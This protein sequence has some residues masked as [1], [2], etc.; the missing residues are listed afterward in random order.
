MSAP[1]SS[2]NSKWIALE[3]IFL[4]IAFLVN[5]VGGGHFNEESQR[6]FLVSNDI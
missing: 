5:G 6:G 1:T 3:G 2:I 4:T